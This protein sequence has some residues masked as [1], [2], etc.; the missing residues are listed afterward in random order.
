V[1]GLGYHAFSLVEA[2]S[3]A[4]IACTQLIV[5]PA[6]CFQPRILAD[7]GKIMGPALQL[8]ALRSARNWGIGDLG[9]LRTLVEF[10][11]Q[12]GVGIVGV[13]P[14]HAL[15][16][17]RPE[18]ASP[19][20]PS[21]R[22]RRNVLYLA[23]EAIPDFGECPAAR[24]RVQ[25]PEFQARLEALRGTDLVDY[26]GMRCSRRCKSIFPE[27]TGQPGAGLHGPKRTGALR[28]TRQVHLVAIIPNASSTSSTCSGRPNCSS[29]RSWSAHTHWGC[30]SG[31]IRI[32]PSG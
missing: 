5:C 22:T 8:Y 26:P 1:P 19:Y 2:G 6:R 4:L 23:V 31:C 18:E 7:G 15:F 32:W 13:N 20:R 11:G 21:N 28:L 14:L 24:E 17:D 3:G 9:D 27:R 16:P 25:A 30:R 10:A 12:A 29:P